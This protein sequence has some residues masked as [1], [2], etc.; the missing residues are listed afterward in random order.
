ML[1]Y[2]LI[3]LIAPLL[4]AITNYI[5]K[6]LLNKVT[7]P[8]KHIIPVL[9]I[10]SWVIGIFPTV[11]AWIIGFEELYL[12]SY[13]QFFT[14][15]G[16]WV[17]Y[18]LWIYLYLL[19]LNTDTPT[20]V[21]PYF[22]LIPLFALVIWYYF[23]WEIITWYN[24]IWCLL[25]VFWAMLLSTN[26]KKLHFNK[27]TVVIMAVSSLL[28]T[29]SDALFRDVYTSSSFVSSVFWTSLWLT[30][31]W[32]WLLTVKKYRHW[33]SETIKKNG[34]L[35]LW[36]NSINEVLNIVAKLVFFYLTAYM[37]LAHLELLNSLQPLFIVIIWFALSKLYPSN[38]GEY[39]NKKEF[40][41]QI[42]SIIIMIVGVY[43][44][45]M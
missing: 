22:Q 2:I 31:V 20:N 32:L 35:L 7:Y 19:A 23:F 28:F 36:I 13:A 33:F 27:N 18:M 9:M 45:A 11:I 24:L 5:D 40:P 1:Q 8:T 16:S 29:V 37:Y 4:R 17:I 12:M 21:I 10:F 42:T 41:R 3:W 6:W 30:I 26:L 39:R 15:I 34:R 43:F 44:V 25:I 38:M 14:V